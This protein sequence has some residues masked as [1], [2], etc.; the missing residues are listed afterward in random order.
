MLNHFS[1]IL[2][3]LKKSQ[4]IKCCFE[5]QLDSEF[6][7]LYFHHKFFEVNEKNDSS[8]FH[9][10]SLALINHHLNNHNSWSSVHLNVSQLDNV[11]FITFSSHVLNATAFCISVFQYHLS[12]YHQFFF[13]TFCLLLFK[14]LYTGKLFF[15]LLSSAS[16]FI[17]TAFL[18]SA[19]ATIVS[20]VKQ[21]LLAYTLCHLSLYTSTVLLALLE[22][23]I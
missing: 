14:A 9:N 11:I 3:L 13:H 20:Q 23:I 8:T 19:T 18:Q 10:E 5:C 17:E 1:L 15:Q 6:I 16:C 2:F 7:C 22:K 21:R 4:I 12:I